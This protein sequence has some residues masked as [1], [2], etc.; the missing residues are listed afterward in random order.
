MKNTNF[1]LLATSPTIHGINKVVNDYFYSNI[2]IKE[3]TNIFTGNKC[4]IF[5]L[6]NSKGKIENFIIMQDKK[7][8]F[9][10]KCNN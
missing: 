4:K 7:Y 1:N 9:L 10:I 6:F 3:N 2:E 8:K 5:D